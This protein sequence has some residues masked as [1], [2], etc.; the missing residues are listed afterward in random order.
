MAGLTR[1]PSMPC[2][3]PPGTT[4]RG[5]PASRQ[6]LTERELEVLLAPALGH[7]KQEIVETIGI[8]PKT[9]WDHVQR[10]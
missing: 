5:K 6:G 2:S 9:V 10:N 1:T 4:C 8:S 3:P 7:S